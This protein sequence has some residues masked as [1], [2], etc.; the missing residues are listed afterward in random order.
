MR[1]SPWLLAPL[2]VFLLFLAGLHWGA[3]MIPWSVIGAWLTGQPID[4]DLQTILTVFRWPR[5]IL[6]FIV[7]AGLSASGTCLQGMLRNPLVDPYILGVSAGGSLGAG[8]ALILRLA[9]F[10]GIS[11]VPLCAFAGAGVVIV[12]VYGLGHSSRGL[13]MNRLLL[14]GVAISAMASAMLALLLVWNNEGMAAV[15]FWLMGSLA[16]RGWTE[17]GWAVPYV[18]LG[19]VLLISQLHRLHV[20]RLGEEGAA[21]LGV[22]V[23][24]VKLVTLV[25]TT[26][27]TA[28]CVS[29]SG[30]IGFVGLIVPHATRAWLRQDDPRY[31]LPLATVLGGGLLIA[32]DTVARTAIAPQE[33]PVGI[34]TALLGVPF[35]LI[36]VRRGVD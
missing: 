13:H 19:F 5:L 28:A 22:P 25:A 21:H 33:V 27:I 24:R 18:G 14:S 17:L 26:L 31:V 7:G 20:L 36:L 23:E 1:R 35:F 30:L 3:V 34:V 2:A 4:P 6:A 32:A 29:V 9:P 11:P 10:L 12:V 15:V 16:D 8:T